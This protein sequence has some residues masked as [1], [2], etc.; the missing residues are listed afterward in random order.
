MPARTSP[1]TRRPSRPVA[2]M[3]A[4]VVAAVE[5]REELWRSERLY[6]ASM[7]PLACGGAII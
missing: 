7:V 3:L 4:A 1:N 5:A 2:E 6:S